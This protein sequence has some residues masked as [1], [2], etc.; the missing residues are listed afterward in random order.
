METILLALAL[1]SASAEPVTEPVVE[2]DYSTPVAVEEGYL[3]GQDEFGAL[4]EA[5]PV[6]DEE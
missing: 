4:P 1:A 2:P 6:E 3:I 5:E